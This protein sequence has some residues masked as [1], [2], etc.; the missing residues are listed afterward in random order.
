MGVTETLQES[1]HTSEGVETRIPQAETEVAFDE[2]ELVL[3][4]FADTPMTYKSSTGATY[5][6]H[7]SREAI[8]LCEPLQNEKLTAAYLDMKFQMAADLYISLEGKPADE[9]EATENSPVIKDEDQK[10]QP[11]PAPENQAK[12]DTSGSDELPKSIE[13]AASDNLEVAHKPE[14]TST[15]QEEAREATFAPAKPQAKIEKKTVVITVDNSQS[16]HE[17]PLLTVLEQSSASLTIDKQKED[18]PQVSVI[19]DKEVNTIP[20]TDAFAEAVPLA[21]LSID[22][23]D[24]LHASEIVTE[25]VVEFDTSSQPLELVIVNKPTEL[26]L[27]VQTEELL[28][29]TETTEVTEGIELEEQH[30]N[31]VTSITPEIIESIEQIERS[32]FMEVLEKEVDNTFDIAD[33]GDNKEKV[34]TALPTIPP[35]QEIILTQFH[36]QLNSLVD[37]NA[38]ETLIDSLDN[39]SS[40]PTRTKEESL[41]ACL[42]AQ[43]EALTPEEQEIALTTNRLP[44]DIETTL[45]QIFEETDIEGDPD[46]FVKMYIEKYGIG[47]LFDTLAGQSSSLPTSHKNGDRRIRERCTKIA[48][49][50]TQLLIH[51]ESNKINTQFTFY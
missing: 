31:E 23:V 37:T 17:I 46:L 30:D 13:S 12:A 47:E 9:P 2:R 29:L 39:E 14:T 7:G 36:Q 27:P 41:Y 35:E 19:N 15:L 33:N 10:Q 21:E 45:V 24:N 44:E 50:A 40:I 20:E 32:L 26:S 6:A 16:N 22:S 4:R 38:Q 42:A 1:P 3:E 49:F 8:M 25:P 34:D 5:T 28:P 48:R 51:R 43:V 18:V 11:E